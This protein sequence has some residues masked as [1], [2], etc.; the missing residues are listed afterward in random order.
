MSTVE[1]PPL[2]AGRV[3]PL[4]M[5][6]AEF[7]AAGHAL[8]ERIAAFL[9]S[10][11]ARPVTP[12]E[13]PAAVRAALGQGGLPAQGADAA[14]LLERAAALVFDHSLL[15]GH[16][17]FFGYITS[18]AAPIGALGDLL[19]A[20]ANPNCGAWELAPIASEIEAQSLRWIAELM[21]YPVDCDGVL[22]SGGNMANFVCFLAARR[23][24]AGAEVR[25]RGLASGAPL[26][27]YASAETHTWIQKAADLFGHGTAAI[28]WIPVDAGLRLDL[29]ALKRQVAADRAAGER[30]FLVVGT[31]GSVGTGA[32]DP[33]AAMAAFCREERLWLHVDGA[34]GGVAAVLPDAPA[35]LKAL[36]L[37]DSVAVDPHKWLY[38]PIEAGCALVRRPGAL[39]DAFSY[40]PVYYSMDRD[41]GAPANFYERGPQNSRGFRALKVWL[42]L[43]QAGREGLVRLI[44]DDIALARVLFERARAHP[45][46]EPG[47][48]GLSIATFRFVPADL[49]GREA[50]SLEHL[51]RLNEEILKRLKKSGEAFLT[52]AVAQDRYLLRACI[53]NFRTTRADVEALPDL[54]ARVGREAD[55]ELR[56]R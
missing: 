43:Q 17:R 5:S 18:S 52:N 41:P 51:N 36:A 15:N 54:V 20:A 22:V 13:T 32:I 50:A 38:A 31:A 23:A 8:V 47:S 39:E 3:A 53:V 11:R 48:L 12:A 34:Y 49:R 10:M 9:D 6:P 2:A 29:V 56:G 7:R 19:A 4:E 26:R 25:E 16:P 28:R 21:G 44:G 45:D 33:L 27:I 46:L 14:T 1:K 35:D 24:M 30:P 40:R 55:A 37:A 42:G